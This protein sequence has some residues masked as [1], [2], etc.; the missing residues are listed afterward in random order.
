M[1]NSSKYIEV[2]LTRNKKRLVNELSK[3]TQLMKLLAD[4]TYRDLSTEEKKMVKNQTIEVLKTIPSLAIFILPG[5][6]LVLPIILKLI[7]SLLPSSFNEN[8]KDN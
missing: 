2:I 1:N 6:S 3:N 4:S 8:N 5:G 7:P